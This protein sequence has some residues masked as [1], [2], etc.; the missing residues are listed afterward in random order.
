MSWSNQTELQ[1]YKYKCGH[2]ENFVASNQGY[3]GKVLSRFR[4][5]EPLTAR[6]YTCPLC[7]RPTFFIWSAGKIV[8]RIPADSFGDSVGH[9][10]DEVEE[11]YD[12]ARRCMKSGAY[13][14][15][16]MVCRKLLMHI[17]VEKG[18]DENENFAYYVNWLE[19]NHFIPPDGKSWVDRVRTKGNAANHEILLMKREE[20]EELITFLAMLMKIVYEFPLSVAKQESPEQPG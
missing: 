18:G 2:C 15:T 9:L 11:L 7:E 12:E 19:E 6:I 16:V 4:G 20:A 1:P 3:T 10:P 8:E 17:A 14:A 13:T 5:A